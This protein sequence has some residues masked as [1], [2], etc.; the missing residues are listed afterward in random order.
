MEYEPPRF[1]PEEFWADLLAFIE[2][3]RVIPVVGAELLEIED[4]GRMRPL[5]RIA[6]ERLLSKYKLSSSEIVLRDGRELNDAVCALVADGRMRVK[7]LYRPVYDILRQLLAS[8]ASLPSALRELAA[9]RHFDLFATTTPDDL[10][11]RAVD[12]VRHGGAAQTE[13]IAYAPGL[14]ASLRRDIPEPRPSNYSAVFYL[15]GKA[16]AS[17]LF[18]IHDEDALEFAYTLQN[19]LQNGV[20][21]MRMFSELR[22]RHL[23][24]IGC[25]LADWLSRLFLRLSNEK[26][27]SSDDRPKREFL[28][29]RATPEERDLTVFLDRF[30]RDS[31]WYSMAPSEFVTELSRRWSERNP[32]QPRTPGESPPA[33]SVTG[34]IFISYASQDIGA[35]KR[36]FTQLQ[37]EGDVVWLDKSALKPGDDWER[38]IK[39]AVARCDIFVPLLSA[40]TESRTEGYFRLEWREAEERAR[41]M[42]GRKFIFPT[43]IDSSFDGMSAYALVPEAFRTFQY[44]HAPAGQMP[45]ALRGE[46]STELRR[47]QQ[48]RR[49]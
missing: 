24:L 35:A 40:T 13:Q 5:Y 11:A 1:D 17:P 28:I 29:E 22:S 16:E 39:G 9:I 8:Q 7:D 38:Q 46:I 14:P 31:R 36:L 47:L 18:A 15:F 4:G 23:L 20:P 45:E 19:T 2:A 26:R 42:Q 21:P 30:S 49:V 32:L 34:G 33:E 10:L 37:N 41:R 25:N 6:A 12:A 43:V 3:G 48:R 44:A 27:L